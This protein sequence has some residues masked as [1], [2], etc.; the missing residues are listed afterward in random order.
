MGMGNFLPGNLANIAAVVKT[1][2]RGICRQDTCTTCRGQFMHGLALGR[3][4]F[5]NIPYV[6]LGN[7]QGM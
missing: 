1:T 6:P 5:K 3:R 2:H 7:N 4:R